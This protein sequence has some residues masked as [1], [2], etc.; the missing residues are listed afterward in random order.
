[1]FFIFNIP[2]YGEYVSECAYVHLVIVLHYNKRQFA[3]L[4][5]QTGDLGPIKVFLTN[6]HRRKE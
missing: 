5:I 3:L 1:M 2:L 6:T 4:E